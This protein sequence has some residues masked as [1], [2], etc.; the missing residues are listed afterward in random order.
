M[1]YLGILLAL[2]IAFINDVQEPD[3][4]P[5]ESPG[6]D[7]ADVDFGSLRPAAERLIAAKEKQDPQIVLHFDS[8]GGSVPTMF[9]FAT[10]MHHVHLGGTRIVCV[11][12]GM[13]ASAGF[14]ILEMCDYRVA[15]PGSTFLAHE[16]SLSDAGGKPIDL[17]IAAKLCRTLTHVM[18][19]QI[20]ARLKISLA[21]FENKIRD[22]DWWFG[23]EEAL[24][25]GAVD[26]IVPLG[27]Y[28]HA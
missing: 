16:V 25:V 20:A 26:A 10:L 24:R 15:Y 17:E 3:K 13:A 7:I 27:S 21:E 23:A 18:S 28:D 12:D 4:K 22:N 11:V 5:I 9:A 19:M 1:K 6:I 2:P 8:P 14:Y